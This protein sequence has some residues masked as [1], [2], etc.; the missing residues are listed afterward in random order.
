M[1]IALVSPY[2]FSYPGG[3]VRHIISLEH[4]FTLMGHNVKIIAPASSPVTEYGER[5]IPIGKPRPIP[6]SGSIARITISLTLKKKVRQVLERERFDIIHLH[7]PLAPTFGPTVLSASNTINIGTFHAAESK[8]SYRWT[9]AILM[10]GFYKRWFKKLNGRIA[11][12]KPASDFIN[13]HFPSTFT[14]IPNGIDLEHFRPD[15]EPLPQFMDGKFNIVFVGRLEKRKGF[16]Y[17]LKAYRLFKPDIPDCRLIVVGPGTRLRKKYEKDIHDLDIRDVIFAGNVPY[18]D[19][20]RYYRSADVF[21][22]P[23]TGHESFGII[24]LEAMAT[25]RPV[26]ASNISGYA[27]VINNEQEGILV[28]PKQEVPL[29]QAITRLLKNETLRREMGMRGRKT[30]EKYGWERISRQ[31]M[32]YYNQTISRISQP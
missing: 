7:E 13:K 20:P 26:V 24:L 15:V 22:A 2:D 8:P 3:V 19:L 6:T 4:Y 11:V 28:T 9:K 12:S 23:A 25:G 16:E 27:S 18:S 10:K 1:K 32:E 30:A 21:C 5:F 29:A 31:V 17:L 14:I